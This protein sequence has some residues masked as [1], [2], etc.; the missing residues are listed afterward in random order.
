MK[1]LLFATLFSSAIVLSG[2]ESTEVS[3]G[4]QEAKR[5]AAIERQKQQAPVDES[6][7]NLYNAQQDRINRD[8][9]P[10]RADD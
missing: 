3:G 6:A 9:N 10:A 4:N 7:A 8:G 5:R 2:C 1:P